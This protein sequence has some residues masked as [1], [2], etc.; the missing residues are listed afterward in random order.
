MV[1]CAKFNELEV[2]LSPKCNYSCRH[3]A[4]RIKGLRTEEL[5]LSDDDISRIT[6]FVSAYSPKE[7]RLT[8]GEPTL[9]ID[10]ANSLINGVLKA[11]PSTTIAITTNGWFCDT[12]K[13]CGITLN[14]FIKLDSLQI[15]YDRYHSEFTPVSNLFLLKE[16]CDSNSIKLNIAACI[17]SP[18]DLVKFREIERTTGI[19]SAFQNTL[20]T[21][22]LNPETDCYCY[23]H[24]ERKTLKRKCPNING[25]FYLPSLGFSQCCSSLLF[26]GN[27]RIMELI[28]NRNIDDYVESCFSRQ[29]DNNFSVLAKEAGLQMKDFLPK[30]SEPC[31][32]CKLI[33]NKLLLEHL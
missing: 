22:M 13:N 24:F 9:N 30:H 31:E 16:F 7:V 6:N 2:F 11:K 19:K 18:L 14:K 27:R 29:L 1:V 5:T 12:Y 25:L 26:Q 20:P 3:C 4:V 10:I 15:S 23:Q 21:N 17:A 28:C 33:F 8:G 32:L